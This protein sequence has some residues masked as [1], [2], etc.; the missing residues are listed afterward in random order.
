MVGEELEP[1]R[2]PTLQQHHPHRGTPASGGGRQRHRLR[3]PLPGSDRRGMPLAQPL[4]RVHV[5]HKSKIGPCLPASRFLPPGGSA[6]S[7]R[8]K[9]PPAAP[10]CKPPPAPPTAT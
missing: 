3:Q 7:F 10:P 4:K 8:K 1:P 5:R 6:T 2:P 9:A